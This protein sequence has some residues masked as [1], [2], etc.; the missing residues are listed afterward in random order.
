MGRDEIKQLRR[1]AHFSPPQSSFP[2]CI[3]TLSPVLSLTQARTRAHKGSTSARRVCVCCVCVYNART[4]TFERERVGGERESAREYSVC[5]HTHES[6]QYAI[7]AAIARSK[8]CDHKGMS[9]VSLF[10]IEPSV[11]RLRK[12]QEGRDFERYWSESETLG[13]ETWACHIPPPTFVLSCVRVVC[14]QPTPS[15]SSYSRICT[16]HAFALLLLVSPLPPFYLLRS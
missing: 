16:T 11:L 2:A 5:A 12:C 6:Y 3:R 7:Q 13:G 4:Q 8:S 9:T 10:A 1:V 14:K 15:S